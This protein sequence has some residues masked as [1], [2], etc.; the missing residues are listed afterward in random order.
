MISGSALFVQLQRRGFR[1]STLV[2]AANR[3]VLPTLTHY[4]FFSSSDGSGGDDDKKKNAG[5]DDEDDIFGVNFDDGDDKLGPTSQL[6]PK[7]KRDSATGI[8][9]GEVEHEASA[10]DLETIKLATDPAT[11]DRFLQNKVNA[12]WDKLDGY[13][14]DSD[15]E[16]ANPN[17]NNQW[18]SEM[19]R[20]VRQADMG[21]NVLGRSTKAQA[22]TEVSRE[23]GSSIKGDDTGFS[24][25]LTSDEFESFQ[26]YMKTQ[27]KV[28]IA[29][30]DIPVMEH[31]KMAEPTNPLD[32]PIGDW[33]RRARDMRLG[34]PDD[35]ELSSKWMTV[36]AQRQMK[37]A[38]LD[39]NPYADLS[40][41]DLSISKLVNRRN[42]KRIPKELLHQNNIPLLQT[43]VSPTG[44]ILH[45]IHTRLGARDQRKVSKLI[46]RARAMGL[47]P[48][49][50]Q[51]TSEQHG[52]I[53]TPDI[54]DTLDWEKDLEERG[55]TI[56]RPPP[57]GD[58]DESSS[59]TDGQKEQM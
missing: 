50:G 53:H 17:K 22:T 41:G 38:N 36:L 56:Q 43:F 44:Q 10:A 13:K 35:A 47:I 54:D 3:S 58:Q 20:H 48:Y 29:R 4:R 30:E 23:D 33:K 46:R 39:D 7:F 57:G 40:P 5:A 21:L 18:A 42:A 8:M 14:D 11:R 27:H 37:D 31:E 15:S 9:T 19:G 16:E 34:N 52:W 6:P 59:G 28:D 1:S 51:F 55:L 12:Y 26:A 25:R 32:A 49:Q 2:L 24:Q 45:R